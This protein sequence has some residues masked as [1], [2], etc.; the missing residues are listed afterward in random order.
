MACEPGKAQANS[1]AVACEACQ[2][3]EE[4]AP[5]SGM[6]NCIQCNANGE[7]KVPFHQDCW[8]SIDYI[9]IPYLDPDGRVNTA[10]FQEMD[11]SGFASWSRV[12]GDGTSPDLNAAVG[13]WSE[14]S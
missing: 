11:P 5:D 3:L 1:G 6:S 13:F 7:G 10:L 14:S 9:G 12:F 2:Q 8:C 4:Y